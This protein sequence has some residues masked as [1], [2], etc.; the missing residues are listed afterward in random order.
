M[1]DDPGLEWLLSCPEPAVRRLALLDLF[2]RDE[3]DPQVAA[4]SAQLLEGEWVKALFADQ[5]PDGGFG[6]HPYQ[7]WM[8]AHC[9]WY[10]W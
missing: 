9:A 3:S 10:P 2:N 7:K 1:P 4:A 5:E 8:G 6:V